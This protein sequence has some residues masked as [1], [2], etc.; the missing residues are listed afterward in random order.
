MRQ[1]WTTGVA[2]WMFCAHAHAQGVP[3]P[4]PSPDA[5]VPESAPP[6][7]GP[8]APPPGPAA[9]PPLATGPGAPAP[10]AP[11]IAPWPAPPLLPPLAHSKDLGTMPIRLPYGGEPIPAG[12]ALEQRSPRL[13]LAVGAGLLLGGWAGSM[14]G[15]TVATASERDLNA[16]GGALPLFIPVAGPFIAL[17]TTD[18]RG[19][20]TFWL[21][22][23]G[24]VQLAGLT[25]LVTALST[26]E[27]HLVLRDPTP[28]QMHGLMSHN[29]R[30]MWPRVTR[31][32]PTA[33]VPPGYHV[34]EHRITGLLATG[35]AIFGATYGVSALVGLTAVAEGPEAEGLTTMV[36]P[37]VGPVLSIEPSRADELATGMLVADTIAQAA[38]ATILTIG[39]FATKKKLVRDDVVEPS[40]LQGAEV[41]VG[42]GRVSMR[43]PF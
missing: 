11:P 24:F 14:V 4:P 39:L 12:Y 21:W 16:N 2:L 23:D 7:P 10:G 33:P 38:G 27:D 15:A 30:F 29:A 6:P 28:H 1:A 36:I 37:I 25:L 19:A 17:D 8:V 40:P 3:E 34:E 41:D 32:D 42:P 31:Y 26:E 18:S 13:P 5:L 22:T 20:A 35:T 43:V 9:L